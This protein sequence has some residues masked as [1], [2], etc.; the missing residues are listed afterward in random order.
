MSIK[1]DL[2]TVLAEDLNKKF[3]DSRIAYFLDGPNQTPTDVTEWLSTG[4]S[5]LD[6]VIANKPNAGI[7]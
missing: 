3:K 2:A 5:V 1:E 4:C 7:P 6:L